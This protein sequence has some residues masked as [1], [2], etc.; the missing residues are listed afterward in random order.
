MGEH[1]RVP[2]DGIRMRFIKLYI[3]TCHRCGKS[4]NSLSKKPIRC[5]KC[6]SPYYGIP[7]RKKGKS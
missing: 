7:R 6:K 4:W 2:S 3:L 5:G 1:R